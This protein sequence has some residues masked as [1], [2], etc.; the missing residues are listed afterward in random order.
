MKGIDIIE[1][2]QDID[3]TMILR[4]KLHKKTAPLWLKLASLVACVCCILLIGV[5]AFSNL[6]LHGEERTPKTLAPVESQYDSTENNQTEAHDPYVQ[7]ETE[8]PLRWSYSVYDS[9]SP[10]VDVWN[11]MEVSQDGSTMT[12]FDPVN[13][14]QM[15]FE[16]A[17]KVWW[18]EILSQEAFDKQLSE[19]AALQNDYAEDLGDGWYGKLYPSGYFFGKDDEHVYLL[20]TPTDV[21]YDAEDDQCCISYSQYMQAGVAILD[22][23][24]DLNPDVT[25]N[26]HWDENVKAEMFKGMYRYTYNPSVLGN[27]TT[28]CTDDSPRN[29]N[30]Q[31]ACDAINGI[32]VDPGDTFSFNDTV[33]EQTA[34]KGYQEANIYGDGTG[35]SIIGGGVSEVASSLYISCLQAELT[36]VERH[37]HTYLAGFVQGGMDAAVYWGSKDFK[38]TNPHSY[39]VMISCEMTETALTVELIAVKD[40]NTPFEEHSC[41]IRPVSSEDADTVTY[42]IVR[43]VYD[44]DNNLIRQDS[45]EELDEMGC[46]TSVYQRIDAQPEPGVEAEAYPSY[47]VMEEDLRTGDGIAMG[48]DID[49]VKELLGTPTEESHTDTSVFLRYGG[50]HY[51]FTPC[52]SCNGWHLTAFGADTDTDTIMPLGWGP[53]TSL[54]DV[55]SHFHASDAVPSAQ[56]PI[57]R[58]DNI[59]YVWYES[60]DNTSLKSIQIHAGNISARYMFSSQNTVSFLEFNWSGD[61]SPCSLLN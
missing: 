1:A 12:F 49:R 4:A 26:P 19:E 56:E 5:L 9:D 7:E 33:G 36:I 13:R 46:G 37:S 6:T 20:H 17:G 23:I 40:V 8:Y 29:T 45:T 54:D 55:L 11:A 43:D 24:Q 53:G 22:S 31:L 16:T 32:M 50:T 38:F 3:E 57:Y 34:E 52:D 21:Q 47:V 10:D 2:L 14:E 60:V 48:D 59:H 61:T 15:G 28:F 27:H 51:T 58:W 35:E 42:T 30:L 41:M 18:I 25:F 44:A 39:T